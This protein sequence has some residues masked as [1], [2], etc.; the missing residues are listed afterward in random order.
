MLRKTLDHI[1]NAARFVVPSLTRSETFLRN[2][3][4]RWTKGGARDP[5]M[6]AQQR[7]N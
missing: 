3:G 6:G 7:G 5:A 1:A 4:V 2:W